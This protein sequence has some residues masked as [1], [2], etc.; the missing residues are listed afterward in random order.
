MTTPRWQTSVGIWAFGATAT[1]FVPGGYHPE[2]MA[3]DTVEKV[4]VAVEGLGPLVDGYEFHYETEITDG[5][6]HQIQEALGKDHD[7]YT[8]CYGLVPNPRFKYG[9]LANPDAALRAEAVDHIKRGIDLAA[10]VGAKFIYWPGNE[11]YN[12]PFQRDYAKTWNWFLEG[13]QAGVEHANSKNVT[14]L[15]EHKN[16]EPAMQILMRNIG[17]SMY[18][19][20]KI[21]EMGTDTR[22]LKVNMDWQHLIMNNEPLG[23]CAAHLLYENM[24]GHQHANSGWGSFDDD[25]MT[26]AQFIEQQIDLIRELQKGG[27]GKNGERI[28]FDLFPYTEDAVEAVKRSVIQFEYMREVALRI[29]DAEMQAAKEKADA[30][31]AYRAFWKALGLTPEFEKTVYERYSKRG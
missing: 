12:Y 4:K 9:S 29:D 16:S 3:A 28:G 20:K 19:V 7:I 2:A 6:A 25:N 1:R 31:G 30:V 27:Y 23:E 21:K 18:I 15:L 8:V 22:N 10:S 14:F 17:T 5:N 26:G 24:L 11:G 13:I